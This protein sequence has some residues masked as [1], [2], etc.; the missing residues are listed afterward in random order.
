[1]YEIYNSKSQTLART[2][3]AVLDVQRR[4]LALWHASDPSSEV[5]LTTPI[6]YFDRMRIRLPGDTSFILGPHVDGGSIERWEDPGYRKCWSKILEGGSNWRQHDSFDVSPRLDA[7]QD[8][9]NAA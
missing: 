3:P 5:D 9:Y 6:S 2:H 1:M 7:N 8:L 4:L